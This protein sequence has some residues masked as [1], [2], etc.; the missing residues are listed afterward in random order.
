MAKDYKVKSNIVMENARLV[1]RNFSGK[2]G[3][4]NPPGQRNFGV[5]LDPDLANTLAKD[6]WNVKFFKPKEPGDEPQAWLKVAV[7]FSNRPP[8]VMVITDNY[9]RHL[10]E[11]TIHMLDWADIKKVDLSISPYN[12]EVAGKSGVAAYL[13]KLFVTIIEDELSAKYHINPGDIEYD[14]P[15]WDN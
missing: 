7:S 10:Y 14:Q 9:R 15:P 1:L 12:W 8:E 3:Q 2:E 5:L 13:H 11:D 4:Y 6:G